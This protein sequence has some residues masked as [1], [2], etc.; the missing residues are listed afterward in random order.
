MLR[1]RYGFEDRAQWRLAI[2]QDEGGDECGYVI[3]RMEDGLALIS[4]FF[5]TDPQGLTGALLHAHAQFVFAAGAHSVS[6][7]FLG[8]QW[9]ETAFLSAG[10]F[11]AETPGD[12]VLVAREMSF[13]ELSPSQCYFTAYDNDD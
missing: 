1:W 5:S 11:L 12:R 2:F 13:G 4:D 9:G 3:W 10:Y 6:A 7:S 8:P